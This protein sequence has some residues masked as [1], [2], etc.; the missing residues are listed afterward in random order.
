MNIYTKDILAAFQDIQEANDKIK[1]LLAQLEPE[2][3]EAR[4]TVAGIGYFCT[5]LETLVEQYEDLF[6]NLEE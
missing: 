2:N 3:K 4:D 6:G 1:N 5:S